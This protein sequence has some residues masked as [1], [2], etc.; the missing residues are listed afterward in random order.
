MLLGGTAMRK[1]WIIII[2][3]CAVLLLAAVVAGICW[4]ACPGVR[5]SGNLANFNLKDAKCYIIAGDQVI[6]QTTMTFEGLYRDTDGPVDWEFNFEIPGYTDIVK[7]E[8][9]YEEC[10]A[11]KIDKRWTAQYHVIVDESGAP[12]ADP[13]NE[14]AMVI[15]IMDF[16]KNK[17]VARV[18]FHESYKRDNVYAVCADSE[19]EA[20]EIFREF[21]QQ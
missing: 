19:E 5:F 15:V 17:P 11:N 14:E 16:I 1:K 20:L 21:R 12:I 4:F 7:S 13:K 2:S 18:Y 8:K 6:D 10:F 3:I 9:I